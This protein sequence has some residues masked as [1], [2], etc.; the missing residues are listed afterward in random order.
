MKAALVI[1]ILANPV[2][3]QRGVTDPY[4]E[5]PTI[6]ECHIMRSPIR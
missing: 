5:S 3:D 6:V 1:F 2:D 4:E